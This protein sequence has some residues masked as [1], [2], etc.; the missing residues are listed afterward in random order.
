MKRALLTV[1]FVIAA[2]PTAHAD[3]FS[4]RIEGHAGG[5]GGKT[6]SGAVKDN[7]RGGFYDN[8]S[9]AAWGFLVGAEALFI[10]AWVEHHEFVGDG[11]AVNGTWTQFMAGLDLDLDFGQER[12]P[13]PANGK[14]GELG[15]PSKYVELGFGIGYGV[16]TGQQVDLPLDNSEVSDKGFVIEGRFSAGLI[17]GRVIG[18]GVTVPVSA[19][20]FFKNGFA[21]DM[22]NQYWSAQGAVMLV[23]RGKIKIK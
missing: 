10:D 8:A 17:V 19:G 3:V 21:N 9:G 2:A 7:G 4:I 1:A 15:P 20:Y 12:G 13:A 6:L 16:G 5:G 22:D 23:V 14:Q 18:L 11:R